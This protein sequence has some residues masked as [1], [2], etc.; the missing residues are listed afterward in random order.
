MA[1]RPRQIYYL[2]HSEDFGLSGLTGKICSRIGLRI[3]A[4][5]VLSVAHHMATEQ[6]D[7]QLGTD[8]RLLLE[9]PLSEDALRRAW[10]AATRAC[11]DPTEDGQG[12]RDWLHRL[13]DIC[14]AGEEDVNLD[15]SEGLDEIRPQISEE[16]L[17]D[18]VTD[19]IAELTPRLQ[20]ALPTP[21]TVAALHAIVQH[22]DAE[23]G[24]RMFLRA[25]KAYSVPIP[26]EQ[27]TRLLRLA[28]QLAYHFSVIH[29]DLNVQWPRLD[30]GNRMLTSGRFGLP[31]LASQF[32]ADNWYDDATPRQLVRRFIESDAGL[33]PGTQAAVLLDDT[34]RLVDSPLSDRVIADLWLA[35]SGRWYAD[36]Q[37]DSTG[38]P[39]LGEIIDECRTYLRDM[40]PS[41]RPRLAPT[42]EAL[43]AAVLHEVQAC[44]AVLD[45]ATL[46][47]ALTEGAGT[48]LEQAAMATAPDLTFRL[49]LETLLIAESTVSHEQYARFT[50]LGEHFGYH[51]DYVLHRQGLRAAA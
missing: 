5:S 35:S 1:T 44:R 47:A 12:I 28:E 36:A 8:I 6:V 20:Y 4:P 13:A 41:Y 10:M 34:Q 27:H 7:R 51:P 45:A 50:E 29:A 2:D 33:A 16:A 25:V 40:D 37:F 49:L 43:R 21:D 24:L 23:L 32:H 38:R 11:F 3:D 48:A 15:E 22:A 14:P 19:E 39:W 18:L 30:P 42:Q 31:T 26:A 46:H 9:A 17:R